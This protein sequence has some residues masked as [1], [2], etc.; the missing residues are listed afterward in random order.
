MQGSGVPDFKKF[1]VYNRGSRSKEVDKI[2]ISIYSQGS[3][4]VLESEPHTKVKKFSLDSMVLK[5]LC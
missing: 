2:L 5:L 4:Q 1:F 3:W